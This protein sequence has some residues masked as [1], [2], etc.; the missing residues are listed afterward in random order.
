MASTERL[1]RRASAG[2]FSPFFAP[3]RIFVSS[4]D[5][6]GWGRRGERRNGFTGGIGRRATAREGAGSA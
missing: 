5:A 4:S 3:A 1:C 6:A 2:I